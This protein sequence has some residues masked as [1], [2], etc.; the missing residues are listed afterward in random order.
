MLAEDYRQLFGSPTAVG[1]PQMNSD[2]PLAADV[3]GLKDW[4]RSAF[5][6]APDAA[7]AP[8]PNPTPTPTV[9]PTPLS[10]SGLAVSPQPV[11]KNGTINF[12]L[13]GAATA[14][15]AIATARGT[16][17]KTLLS[18]VAEPP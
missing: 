3:P 16:V 5:S 18:G 4:F 15:V 12:S 7:P 14:T 9:S 6:T 10:I 2:I 11:T 13:S 8:T 1:Y 17:V